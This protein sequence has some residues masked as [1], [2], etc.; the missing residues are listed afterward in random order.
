M[1]FM[2]TNV[3]A[4][5]YYS[6]TLIQFLIGIIC[7][8]ITFFV[9]RDIFTNNY[10]DEYKYSILIFLI[11]DTTFI[12]YKTK[13]IMMPDDKYNLQNKIMDYKI[14]HDIPPLNYNNTIFYF[15][16]S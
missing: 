6:S 14:I 4:S 7:Y 5:K 8:F 9:I 13:Y 16:D 15:I 12:I 10:G 11:I 1:Y 3:L 2:A